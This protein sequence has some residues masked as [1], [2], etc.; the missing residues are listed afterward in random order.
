MG[1]RR[2]NHKIRF[3]HLSVMLL[4]IMLVFNACTVHPFIAYQPLDTNG[5]LLVTVKKNATSFYE[6]VNK[7]SVSYIEFS[8]VGSDKYS[9]ISISLYTLKK[10]K[11]LK[12]HSLEFEFEGKKKIVRIN[13]VIKLDQEDRLFFVEDDSELSVMAY[14]DYIYRDYN[15]IKIY[16]Q[17]IFNKNDDDIGKEIDLTLKANYSFDNGDIVTQENKY[18]VYIY[19]TEPV[20]PNWMYRLFP[21]M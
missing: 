19:K 16:T 8:R 3:A 1:N 6:L 14:F 7:G 21:E 2:R 4:I 13:K 9:Q 10:Y 5:K 18:R 20:P 11:T 15:K 12:I 17:R